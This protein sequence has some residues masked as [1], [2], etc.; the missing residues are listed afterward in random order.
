MQLSLSLELPP[1]DFTRSKIFG[2]DVTPSDRRRLTGQLARVHDLMIDGKWRSLYAISVLTNSS[3]A[4][5][6]ARLRDLRHKENGGYT[7][8]K[9][10][11]AAGLFE[12][13]VI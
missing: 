8:E 13:R 12:Y 3:E 6:S 4:S 5:A 10:R 1:R 2:P 11:V 7:V 9:R